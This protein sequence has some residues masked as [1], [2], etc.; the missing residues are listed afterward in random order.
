MG[1]LYRPVSMMGWFVTSVTVAAC[2]WMFLAVDRQSHS[3]SDTPV[4][5]FPYVVSFLVVGGWI[6]AKTSRRRDAV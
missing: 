1:W 5:V 2:V 3:A 4:G 6:A